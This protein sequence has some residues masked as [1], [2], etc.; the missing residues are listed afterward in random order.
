MIDPDEVAKELAEILFTTA[1][2]G[3]ADRLVLMSKDGRDLGGWADWAVRVHVVRVIRSA[4][5]HDKKKEEK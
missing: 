2:N 4:M 1:T 3:K 5:F